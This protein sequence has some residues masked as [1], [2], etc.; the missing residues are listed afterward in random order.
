VFVGACLQERVA[1]ITPNIR[2][3]KYVLSRSGTQVDEKTLSSLEH[4]PNVHAL[5]ASKLQSARQT[6]VRIKGA[7]LVFL[8]LKPPTMSFSL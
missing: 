2:Y 7:C 4:N 3:C 1:E 6:Q 8:A 5:L